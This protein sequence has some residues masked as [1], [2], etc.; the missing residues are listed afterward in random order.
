MAIAFVAVPAVLWV[1]LIREHYWKTR[2]IGL[3]IA[4]ILVILNIT[5]IWL[6][7]SSDGPYTSL[8]WIGTVA[9][10]ATLAALGVMGRR[11]KI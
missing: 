2:T 5:M 9:G 1:D 3:P 4:V 10:L 8:D 7:R 11:T 6:L